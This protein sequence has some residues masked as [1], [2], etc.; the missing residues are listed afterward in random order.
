MTISAYS[1]LAVLCV[2]VILLCLYRGVRTNGATRRVVIWSI[3]MQA[4]SALAA[5]LLPW[6]YPSAA[7]WGALGIIAGQAGLQWASNHDW[8]DGQPPRFMRRRNSVSAAPP[9]KAFAQRAP[10]AQ[11]GPYSQDAKNREAA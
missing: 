7:V 1:T 11:N 2:A 9:I 10:Q 8:H 6:V 4:G 5:L 3:A